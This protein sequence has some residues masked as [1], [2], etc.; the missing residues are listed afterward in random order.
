MSSYPLTSQIFVKRKVS[1]ISSPHHTLHNKTVFRTKKLHHNL[2]CKKLTQEHAS[3]DDFLGRGNTNV[4]Y[5]LNRLPTKAL[6]TRTPY[7]VWFGKTCHHHTV[8]VRTHRLWGSIS[9]LMNIQHALV[10]LNSI[11]SSLL[12]QPSSLLFLLH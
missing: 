5:L 11:L 3:P 12:T 7:E 9:M 8:R 2:H 4:A 6:D 1:S 10:P